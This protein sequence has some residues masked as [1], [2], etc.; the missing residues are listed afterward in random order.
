MT[1][2]LLAAALVIVTMSAAHGRTPHGKMRGIATKQNEEFLP[3]P[4]PRPRALTAEPPAAAAVP[5]PPPG[6]QNVI[7]PGDATQPPADPG[8]RARLSEG[9]VTAAS[10]AIPPQPDSRCTVAD[11]V[12]LMSLRLGDGSIVTFPDEPA[13]ACTTAGVFTS[14]VRELLAP[15][16]KGTFAAGLASVSTGPGLECRSRDHV[17]GAKLSAHGQGLAIDVASMVLTGGRTIT[18][19]A[20]ATDI[21]RGFE[22]AARSA[23]CGYFHTAL[24]PGADVYHKNHWHFDL[25]PRGASGGGKFCQ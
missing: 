11:P 17:P 14:Y 7:A 10:I 21:D 6:A 25:E 2:Y 9:G 15:L 12:K 5:K 4:V 24:G 19:G 18:V 16:A 3:V 8:C 22:A 23:G 13:I 20:P 1:G